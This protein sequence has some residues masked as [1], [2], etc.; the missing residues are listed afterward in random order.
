MK[1][2]ICAI[3]DEYD[4]HID[5]FECSERMFC[6]HDNCTDCDYYKQCEYCLNEPYCFSRHG[7]N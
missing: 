7:Y 2:S 1:D 3:F 6:E 5:E 4:Y